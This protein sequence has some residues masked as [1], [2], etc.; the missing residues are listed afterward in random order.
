MPRNRS[1]WAAWNYHDFSSA[2][3][4]S[5]GSRVSLTANLN[6]HYPENVAIT[7][8]ILTTLNPYRLPDPALTQGVFYHSHPIYDN[9]AIKAQ[10]EMNLIQGVRGIHFAGAWM[11]YGFH[12]DGLGSA[13]KVSQR[14]GID[15]P[16]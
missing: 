9:A 10:K 2:D 12:E 15:P 3:S 6:N 14:M 1:A 16:W 8:P 4:K 13:V 11:G 5:A 7:G